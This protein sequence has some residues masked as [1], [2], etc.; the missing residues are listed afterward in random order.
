MCAEKSTFLGF[1]ILSENL[2][3]MTNIT[4]SLDNFINKWRYFAKIVLSSF[5]SKET[6][7]IEEFKKTAATWK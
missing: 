1:D 6:K 7:G 4:D 5:K 2:T 3:Q